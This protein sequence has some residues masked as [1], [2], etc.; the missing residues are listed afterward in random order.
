MEIKSF[1]PAG[2]RVEQAFGFLQK[3][4]IETELLSLESDQSM[5]SA[6]TASVSEFDSVLKQNVKN[7]HT[8]SVTA[9]DAASDESW[10]AFQSYLKSMCSHPNAAVAS[11]ASKAYA[12]FLKFGNIYKLPYTQE[13]AAMHNLLQEITALGSES[14]ASAA[15]QE[16]ID[17]LQS[18]YDTF[19]EAQRLQNIESADYRKGIIQAQFD[20]CNEAYHSFVKRVN[21]LAMINGEAPYVDFMKRVNALIDSE[22]ATM[23]ARH[24]R[25][26]AKKEE[27]TN[28]NQEQ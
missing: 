3:V 4:G 10:R 1:S 14:I 9:A 23:A 15:L 26:D 24:G 27:E 28:N 6:Y 8:D 25:A 18:K 7:S 2:L 19:M 17:D 12:S 5:V 20:V 11:V 21:A 16:W 13:Y 22:L